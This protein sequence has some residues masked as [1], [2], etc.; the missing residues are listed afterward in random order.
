[1]TVKHRILWFEDQPDDDENQEL[2]EALEEDFDFCRSEA[3]QGGAF[4]SI[5]AGILYLLHSTYG[6]NQEVYPFPDL[7]LLDSKLDLDPNLSANRNRIDELEIKKDRLINDIHQCLDGTQMNGAAVLWLVARNFLGPF[8]ELKIVYLSKWEEKEIKRN[9]GGRLLTEIP[10]ALSG[11]YNKKE[12]PA[13]L[14]GMLFE[15]LGD[16]KAGLSFEEIRQRLLPE[17]ANYLLG[18]PDKYRWS[19]RYR[20]ALSELVSAG[21]EKAWVFHDQ[22][23]T[24]QKPYYSSEESDFEDVLRS[25]KPLPRALILGNRGSGKEGF[26]RALHNL[27]YRDEANCPFVTVN[28]GGVPPWSAGSA[29]QLRL[30]GGQIYQDQDIAY[31]C[32]PEA[33]NGSLMLDEI[34]DAQPDVQDTLLRLIQ[35]GEYEPILFTPQLW[36]AHCCFIGATNKPLWDNPDFR[37]DVADRLA[38]YVIRIPG[39]KEVKEDIPNWLLKI[40]EGTAHKLAA[41]T[42]TSI[43]KDF[44][45]LEAAVN[46]IQSYDWPG[47]LRELTN[48][49]RRV[50][51]RSV[52]SPRIRLSTVISELSQL[53]TKDRRKTSPSKQ[54]R[55][56][57]NEGEFESFSTAVARYVRAA[58]KNRVSRE[59]IIRFLKASSGRDLSTYQLS[60]HFDQYFGPDSLDNFLEDVALK[61]GVPV[62]GSGN[63]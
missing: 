29:L 12:G 24:G 49:I 5:S 1:M 38:M 21:L 4:H 61:A 54:K 43:P 45:F 18:P 55:L 42:Q 53:K 44:E 36:A 57:V 50:Q 6:P 52:G 2:L 10:G 62:W 23:T 17:D 60:S 37:E 3:S 22:R 30:F 16:E 48:F 34:G 33:W 14:V 7:I 51:M 47:N 20:R 13:N 15:I 26:A 31:G 27:W 56:P 39:L 25:H 46:I 58:G 59:D 28:V 40:A 11:Y 35:E 9:H 32:V 19:Q 63:G 41:M 8:P